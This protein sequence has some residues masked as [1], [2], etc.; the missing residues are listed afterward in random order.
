MITI[1]LTTLIAVVSGAEPSPDAVRQQEFREQALPLL[2]RYCFDCH[3][4]EAQEGGLVLDAFESPREIL[5]AKD[6]WFQVIQKLRVQGMPPEDADPP[7]EEEREF[8]VEWICLRTAVT[9][10]HRS[11]SANRQAMNWSRWQSKGVRRNAAFESLE[12]R[13]VRERF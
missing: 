1:G 13:V 8:L 12:R 10:S 4:Q 7:A 2:K 3:G 11:P 9:R 5:E 6:T